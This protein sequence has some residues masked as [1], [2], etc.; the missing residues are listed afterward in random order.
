MARYGQQFKDKAVARLLPPESASASVL[1]R[2]IGVSE[3]TLER[4]LSQALAEPQRERVWTAAARFDAV[5]TTASM[6]EVTRN[7]WCRSNGVYPQALAQWR[8]AAQL[9]LV[10][11]GEL[12]GGGRQD[13]QDRRRIRDLERELQRKEKALAETA[14]LLVLFKK[15]RGDLQQRRGRMIV[16]ED[17]R[18]LVADVEQAHRAGA[19][20]QQACATVGI[21]VRTLQRWKAADG[22]EV[23]DRRPGA[24][25]SRPAHALTEAERTEILAVV[26]QARFADMPPACIVPM[27]ADEGRYLASESSFSRLLREHGQQQHR[28]RARA[29]HAS[30]APSTHIATAPGQ[31]WCWDMTYLPTEVVGR[32]FHLFLIL[33][34]YSRKI[35]GWEVHDSDGAEHAT[36]LV[37]RTALAEQIA[38]QAPEQRPVLH[39]D[40]GASFKATTVLA[41]LHWLGIRPSYSR[42]RV[43][44]DNAFVEALFRTAKYRPEFPNKGFADLEAARQWAGAFVQWYNHDHR[45]SGIGYVSPAQRHAG[46][47]VA[48]LQ[49]RHALYQQAHQ[50]NPSRWSGPTRNWKRIEAVA[51]NPEKE[52]VVAAATKT[53][54]VA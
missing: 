52:S 7:A 31:V 36:Q 24:A 30:R 23:G 29:P 34:L 50:A 4:W 54:M 27:L 16:L 38:L 11:P 13:T 46:Q 42:P 37:R 19:R 1:S 49:A 6:E 53:Q 8:A 25:R 17:R 51:L 47:D 35:L 22:L 26:N 21:D 32:W 43:S 39:G 3:A 48:I 45:H 5:L 33:D 10:E 44:D 41:M 9:S 20:L 12:G 18:S 2:E 14:A 40:N 28:G 15:A